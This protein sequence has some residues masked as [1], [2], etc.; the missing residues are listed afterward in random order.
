MR[1]NRAVAFVHVRSAFR[2]HAPYMDGRAALDSSRAGFTLESRVSTAGAAYH[3]FGG[4][5]G[6]VYVYEPGGHGA[7]DDELLLFERCQ[8][9]GAG[10]LVVSY[11]RQRN[12]SARSH[13]AARRTQTGCALLLLGSLGCRSQPGEARSSVARVT[14]PEITVAD[15]QAFTRGTTGFAWSLHRKLAP[16]GANFVAGKK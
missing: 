9:G 5:E 14:K 7:P 11:W 10:L 16:P 15:A 8:S 2:T 6:T 12:L 3:R 1:T 13:A 4:F